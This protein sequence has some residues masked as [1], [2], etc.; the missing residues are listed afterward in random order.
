MIPITITVRA[1]DDSGKKVTSRIISVTSNE[2]DN[3][4]GD[5]DTAGD[6]NITGPLKLQL[7]AERSG[8]GNDRIYTITI[9][10]KDVA[11]NI[12]YG[13]TT[14]TAPHDMKKN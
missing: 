2:P 5:G 12:T 7:R 3:G 8:L 4:L 9:E 6:W 11:G 14:V 13:T 1:T 10:S